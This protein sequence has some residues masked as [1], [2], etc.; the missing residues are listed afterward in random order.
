MA[1]T[2]LFGVVCT[3][4]A[5]AALAAEAGEAELFACL[6]AEVFPAAPGLVAPADLLGDRRGAAG[7]GGG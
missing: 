4:P 7:S 5:A 1:C 6:A 3:V 2:A